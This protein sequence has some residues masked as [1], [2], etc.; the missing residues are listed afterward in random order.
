[1][2]ALILAAGY[3]VRLHPLTEN[4]P[5]PLLEV[6]S[7][8]LLGHI[9]DKIEAL[10]EINEV[11]VVT[12][13]KFYLQF[14]RWLQQHRL[15]KKISHLNDGTKNNEN[16][17]GAVG[18]LYFVLQQC[19]IEEPLLVIAGD[20]LFGFSLP[21]FV[22]RFQKVKHSCVAFYDFQDIE[23]VRKKYGVGVLHGSKVLQFDE[24]PEK[25][26]S[27]L[28]STACYIFTPED[29]AL[30][31]KA[32]AHGGVDNP[33]DF[34]RFLIANSEVYSFVFQEHWFDIGSFESLQAARKLY[35]GYGG[36]W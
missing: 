31:P 3:A 15:A 34:I 17:L 21:R 25:P 33:G 20:N 6:G 12:N 24:K 16:R 28:A 5:K 10:P 14:Q 29:L 11:L 36:R 7:K 2:K 22:Q 27:S 23:K 26:Q 18:D 9:L 8:A 13:G 19:R 30:V 4:Q 1:M 32:L 35:H